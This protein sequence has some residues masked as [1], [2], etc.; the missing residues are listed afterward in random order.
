MAFFTSVNTTLNLEYMSVFSTIQA[1]SAQQCR[2]FITSRSTLFTI[3]I[4]AYLIV[5]NTSALLA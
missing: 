1:L 2:L 4:I 3:L 5:W